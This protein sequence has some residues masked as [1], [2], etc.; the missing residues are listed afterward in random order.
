MS[1]NSGVGR[2]SLYKPEYCE[3]IL[4]YFSVRPY[5]TVG[6][7]E[8]AADFPS[9]AGFAAKIGV[10]RDTLHEWKD[11]HP[12]FSDAYMRAKEHQENFVLVN[13]MKGLVNTNFAMFATKNLLGYRDKQPGETDVV[14]NNYQ[15]APEDELKRRAE[16]LAREILDGAGDGDQ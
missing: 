16:I 12:E 9:F 14:V 2:P 8:K 3:L 1:E 10:H 4:E 15:S 5:E 7:N 13:G 11:I 6:I